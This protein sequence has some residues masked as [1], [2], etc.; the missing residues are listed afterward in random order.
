MK[1]VRKLMICLSL[2][3]SS[4][5][6]S[7]FMMRYFSATNHEFGWEPLANLHD[8]S[9]TIHYPWIVTDILTIA[10]YH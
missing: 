3:F 10:G 1:G 6:G 8:R 5:E 9:K 7:E 2:E 4:T